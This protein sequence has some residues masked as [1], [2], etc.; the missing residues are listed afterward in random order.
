VENE[1]RHRT[2]LSDI[3]YFYKQQIERFTKIGIGN[4]TEFNTVITDSLIN[5]TLKRLH[6]LQQKRDKL[7]FVARSNNGVK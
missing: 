2:T 5:I 7:V 1:S 3:I 6:E 4:Q